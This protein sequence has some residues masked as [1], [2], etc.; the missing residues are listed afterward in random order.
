[1]YYLYL[2]ELTAARLPRQ[3]GN[4]HRFLGVSRSGGV[5]QQR[6]SFGDML[7]NVSVEAVHPAQ[8]ESDD[9][10]PGVLHRR[11]NEV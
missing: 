4:S 9:L 11:V 6:Y 2:D 8:R 10:S 7:K 1:M 5:R 3:P